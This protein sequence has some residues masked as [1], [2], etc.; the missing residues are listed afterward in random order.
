M[1]SIGESGPCLRQVLH[2]HLAFSRGKD[3]FAVSAR[4]A[5]SLNAEGLY[6]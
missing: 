2:E 1:L 4:C 5:E 6:Q 3:L